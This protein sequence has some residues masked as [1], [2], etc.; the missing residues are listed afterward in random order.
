MGRFTQWRLQYLL[1]EG[2]YREKKLRK[3]YVGDVVFHN[4]AFLPVFRI[5]ANETRRAAEQFH[6]FNFAPKLVLAPTPP[7]VEK[8]YLVLLVNT[9]LKEEEEKLDSLLQTTSGETT[10]DIRSRKGSTIPKEKYSPR[11]I[12]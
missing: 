4:S 1:Q 9:S 6:E 8:K 3:R 2:I 12:L 11:R 7:E 5:E 10:P